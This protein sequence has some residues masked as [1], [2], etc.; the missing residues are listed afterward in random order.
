MSTPFQAWN[1]P[2]PQTITGLNSQMVY[3]EN[4]QFAAGLNHQIALGS[5]LQLCINPVALMDLMEMPNSAP[6]VGLLG[7]GVGGNNQLTIGTSTNIVW[8]RQFELFMGPEKFEIKGTKHRKASGA[9]LIL[10][11]AACIAYPIAFNAIKDEDGRAKLVIGFQVFIDA[12]LAAL[13][14]VAMFIEHGER[15][16][17]EAQKKLFKAAEGDDAGKPWDLGQWI[18]YISLLPAT[19]LPEVAIADEE[20]KF[21]SETNPS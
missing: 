15:E 16:L 21:H 18:T 17:I 8:G 6:L 4:I 5:N 11:G 9:F 19:I 14:I 7:S 2:D 3:G 12:C 10:I 1:N 20:G 13:V